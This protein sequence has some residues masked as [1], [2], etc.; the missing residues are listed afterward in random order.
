MTTGILQIKQSKKMQA[1]KA[2]L[3]GT[4]FKASLPKVAGTSFEG[5]ALLFHWKLTSIR[6]ILN[7][8]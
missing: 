2:S 5:S 6:E 4:P 7:Q 3:A 8:M 1:R